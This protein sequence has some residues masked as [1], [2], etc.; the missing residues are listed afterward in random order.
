MNCNTDEILYPGIYCSQNEWEISGM[1]Q[2]HIKL[3][4]S[5]RFIASQDLLSLFEMH[6]LGLMLIEINR[7]IKKLRGIYYVDVC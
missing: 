4:N 3:M 5:S 7:F 1:N 2:L 6:E